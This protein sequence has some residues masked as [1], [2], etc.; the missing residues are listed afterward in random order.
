MHNAATNGLKHGAAGMLVTDWGDLGHQQLLAVSLASFAYGAAAGWNLAVTPNP[1]DAAAS[2][3]TPLLQAMSYHLF[4]DPSGTFAGLAYDLGL[5]YERFGWQR[6]NGSVDWFLFREKWDF[7]NYVNR[8]V[9][10]NLPKVVAACEK[11][12]PRFAAAELLRP[13]GDLLKAEFVFTCDE[14]V[15]TCRRTAL[16]QAW[17]AADPAK[18][19]PE[20]ETL[21]NKPPRPLPAT[22]RQEM[23]ALGTDAKTLRRQYEG[24]WLA[25]NKRS[26]LADVT[27][28]FDRLVTEYT[29]F[30]KG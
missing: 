2:A 15:H 4:Q 1:H 6:F 13:D 9:P 10:K 14:I 16:R 22:F 20:E 30:A 24:L 25:R 3:V 26:R 19:N 5:M 8:A 27:K 29:A 18:R 23:K 11:L 7:A 17:L 21:R 12:A 28:E